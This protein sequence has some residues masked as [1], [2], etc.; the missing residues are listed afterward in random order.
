MISE[1]VSSNVFA[2]VFTLEFVVFPL[3]F[4]DTHEYRTQ[5]HI[6]PEVIFLEYTW[7]KSQQ[8]FSY[9]NRFICRVYLWN[10]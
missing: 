3:E 4:G 9:H 5:G 10:E 2:G 6:G 8:I 1:A 7:T